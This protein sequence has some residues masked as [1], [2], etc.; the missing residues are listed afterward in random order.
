[1][2]IRHENHEEVSMAPGG[3]KQVRLQCLLEGTEVRSPTGPVTVVL[4]ADGSTWLVR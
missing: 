1:M 2:Y 4:V 3:R